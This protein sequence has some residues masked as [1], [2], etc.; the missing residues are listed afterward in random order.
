MEIMVN[1]KIEVTKEEEERIS[2][3]HQ[4]CDA[5]IQVKSVKNQNHKLSLRARR[6]LQHIYMD[7]WGPYT[8]APNGYQWQ[9]YLL[10]TDDHS[11][12]SWIYMTKDRKLATVQEI[13]KE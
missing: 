6:C 10:L 5:Y 1:I 4:K 3:I 2:E 7:F 13:I 8:K 11:R 12:L 9:Y